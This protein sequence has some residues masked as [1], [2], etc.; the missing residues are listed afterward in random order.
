MAIDENEI[1]RERVI[2]LE[3]LLAEAQERIEVIEEKYL[4]EMNN[5]QRVIGD[6]KSARKV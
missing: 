2:E 1:L 6:R 4:T 5:L 3:A